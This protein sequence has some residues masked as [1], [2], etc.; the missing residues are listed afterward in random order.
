[1]RAAATGQSTP[2]PSVQRR[3]VA[4]RFGWWSRSFLHL[5]ARIRVR[6]SSR[7]G[8][9]RATKLSLYRRRRSELRNFI[10][11]NIGHGCML[12]ELQRPNVSGNIPPLT[13][14]RN[15]GSVLRHGAKSIRDHVVKMPN[16][17]TAQAIVVIR[18]RLLES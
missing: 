18:R 17:I 16:G 11:R 10:L 12:A 7:R 1:M 13:H 3:G 5:P 15:L 14:V 8:H 6:D 2:A 4:R 9:L